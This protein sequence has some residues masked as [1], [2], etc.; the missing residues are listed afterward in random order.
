MET[1]VDPSVE[2]PEDSRVGNGVVI[3]KGVIIS[4]NCVL[5]DC[6]Y[7]NYG[8]IIGHDVQIKR[9]SNVSFGSLIS[10]FACIGEATYIGAGVTIRDE[11][12]IGKN[13]IIGMGSVVTTDIP[14]NVVAY[15]NPCKV[16]RENLGER[17]F[18]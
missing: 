6:S 10:G 7:L 18:R 11:V 1:I 17:V 2:V 4:A 3:Q 8:V 13:T 14:D 9:F 12:T 5:E 15:G 16:V